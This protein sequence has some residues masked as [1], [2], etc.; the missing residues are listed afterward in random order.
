MS[1]RY[2]LMLNGFLFLFFS[3]NNSQKNDTEEKVTTALPNEVNL[4][5]AM[6]IEY[7]DFNHELI[8]NGTI[9]ASLKANLEFNTPEVIEAI[10]V[11]NGTKVAKGQ[12]IAALD[13][14]KLK[15]AVEQT[16]DNLERAKLDLQ[17]VLIG[18]GYTLRDSSKIPP[19]IMK[20]AKIRSNYDNCTAQYQL[21]T[22]NL[23]NSVLYAPFDGIVANLFA[24][25]HNLP[26]LSEPFC[27][28][29]GSNS[30]EAN[31][32]ILE[33]ELPIIHT[34]DKVMIS[35]F[36]ISDYTIEGKIS[37]INPVVDKNGMV[38]IK[39]SIGYNARLY[40]GMNVK[41]HIQKTISKQ[42]VVPKQAVVLRNNRQVIFSLKN[43][44]AIWNYIQTGME[45]ST[46]YVITEGLAE[47][48]SIIYEG[49]LNLAHET[50]V[51][52]IR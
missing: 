45:N 41:A 8:S 5:K 35:P 22:H 34:G 48:D 19:E 11:K 30:L 18:Q 7:S 2:I 29:I 9:E 43:N 16:R 24:K 3:C 31:F 47:G 51:Q 28:I 52:I 38:R 10:Y 36:S 50:P 32:V 46:S 20:L 49:N 44:M 17:D 13:Q 21:A 23:K 14:F 42:L 27:T 40:D 33:S 6:K 37:E 39:A 25:E 1:K 12:K 26:S 15:N 4:V